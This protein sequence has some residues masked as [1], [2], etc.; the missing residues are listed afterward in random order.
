MKRNTTGFGP[1]RFLRTVGQSATVWALA[2]AGIRNDLYQ[3]WDHGFV[4][5]AAPVWGGPDFDGHEIAI[6][7]RT[8]CSDERI[9]NPPT[10]LK[11]RRL[12]S[13]VMS[14]K[15]LGTAIATVLTNRPDPEVASEFMNACSRIPA[16]WFAFAAPRGHRVSLTPEG[17]YSNGVIYRVSRARR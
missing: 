14:S 16:Y 9:D 1:Q 12:P 15:D 13:S 8:Y 3:L 5:N 4:A 7:S 2:G 10:G 6:V 11:C 17:D